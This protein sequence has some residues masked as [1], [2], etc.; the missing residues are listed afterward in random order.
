[1]AA[2]PGDIPGLLGVLEDALAA[3]GFLSGSIHR[4]TSLP[5]FLQ[6]KSVS[7]IRTF[8]QISATSTRGENMAGQDSLVA[9]RSAGLQIGNKH[10]LKVAFQLDP[11][12]G[13]GQKE[14][15]MN[16]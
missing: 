5:L 4:D 6:A 2:G 11:L 15:V 10:D 8:L 7:P 12:Q 13:A 1:M 9:G 3:L 16:R 14:S